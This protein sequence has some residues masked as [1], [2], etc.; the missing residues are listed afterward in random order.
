MNETNNTRLAREHLA[1]YTD[2]PVVLTTVQTLAK[3][4]GIKGLEGYNGAT[5]ELDDH[6][7][8][9][10]NPNKPE[11]QENTFVH[12]VLHGVL[13]YEGFPR[14]QINEQ[15]ARTHLSQHLADALYKLQALFQSVLV[16]PEI[17]RRM[18]ETYN[19]NMEAYYDGLLKQKTNRFNRDRGHGD[20][21]Q[22]FFNQQ[23]VVD[24]L[25]YFYYDVKQRTKILALFKE[26][27]NSAY[28]SCFDLQRTIDKIGMH[29][30][31][32]CR[33]SARIIKA[34]IIKYGEKRGLELLNNMWKA[35]EIV[36]SS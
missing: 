4:T 23:D 26:K 11:S 34:H 36:R 24:G 28:D 19:L 25:E 22:I 7:Q 15:Y 17:Y 33:K 18:R 32:S 16:H 27:S 31:Q 12:E 21:E 35:L 30:P 29:H 13:K 6:I 14:A 20:Q 10:L 1:K 5:V 2:K 3:E 8:I 9:A